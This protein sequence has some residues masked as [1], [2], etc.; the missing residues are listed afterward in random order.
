MSDKPLVYMECKL[1]GK[2]DFMLEYLGAC[3]SC[4]DEVFSGNIFAE[5]WF[6][7]ESLR[8][9]VTREMAIDAGYPEMEGSLID[10]PF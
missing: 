1:C 7:K 2:Y 5:I 10:Y 6:D 8:I 3:E 9:E 4:I